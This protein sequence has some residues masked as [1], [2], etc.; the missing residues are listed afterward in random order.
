MPGSFHGA[1]TM[2]DVLTPTKTVTFTI[3]RV[4]R[5]V[6]DQKTLA[7]L[8][9]LQPEVQKGLKALQKKRDREDNNTYI[10]AGVRWTDR[11]KATRL[12]RVEKD[13]TFTL[14]ITPQIVPDIRS[15]E[16]FLDMKAG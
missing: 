5:R 4:P 10:R 12:T 13:A 8:M 1:R 7:R 11:A 2:S 15:V 9:Q 16:K 3:T 6:A 14:R